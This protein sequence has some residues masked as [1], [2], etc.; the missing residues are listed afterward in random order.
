MKGGKRVR[1]E[2]ITNE[3]EKTERKGKGRGKRKWRGLREKRGSEEGYREG[4]EG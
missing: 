3:W 2:G 1:I 4:S